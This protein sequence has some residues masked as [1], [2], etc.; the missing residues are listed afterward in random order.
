MRTLS[1]M[2]FFKYILCG[3]LSICDINACNFCVEVLDLTCE[4]VD[5]CIELVFTPVR[6]Y[7]FKGTSHKILSDVI[8]DSM[9]LWF[10]HKLHL[11][12]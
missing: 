1:C 4:N 2:I 5:S 11:L 6:K 7:G 8:T 12:S 10:L 3:K 9:G